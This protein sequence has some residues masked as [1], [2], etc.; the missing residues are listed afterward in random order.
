MVKT[1]KWNLL[2]Y[3]LS[4]SFRDQEV[5]G[6]NV[7]EVLDVEE[8]D[9]VVLQCHVNMRT[10]KIKLG[11]KNTYVLLCVLELELLVTLVF[12]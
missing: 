4:V 1:L 3:K 9:E 12:W 7:V 5:V 2:F 8:D 11:G 10:Q 6:T